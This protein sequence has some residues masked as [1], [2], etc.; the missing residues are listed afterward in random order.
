MPAQL[1]DTYSY[2]APDGSV[3]GLEN[4]QILAIP[5]SPNLTTDVGG[6]FYPL[7]ARNPNISGAASFR[8]GVLA[9]TNSSGVWSITLPYGATET[10]PSTPLAKWTLVFPDGSLLTGVVPSDAGP[11][12]VDDLIE[13]HGWAWA[14]Q[15]YVAP[16]TAGVFA[17]GTV[18][19][20]G[21]SATASVVFL[22]P[23]VSNAYQVELTPSVDSN[24]GTIPRVAWSDKTTTGM[25]VNVDSENYVGSVD[26]EAQL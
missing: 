4:Q 20:S 11:L 14:S 8:Y 6:T 17:K 22:S 7:N 24:D 13:D 18:S 9:T 3:V 10:H 23:F 25:T 5:S 16:V 12:S 2:R 19:F 21:G 1:Q 26:W 15:I